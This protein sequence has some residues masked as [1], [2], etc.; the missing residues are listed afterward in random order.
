MNSF[1]INSHFVPHCSFYISYDFNKDYFFLNNLEL[2]K[3]VK[4]PSH[5]MTFSFDTRVILKG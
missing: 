4:I 3:L 1:Q 5:L 2:L